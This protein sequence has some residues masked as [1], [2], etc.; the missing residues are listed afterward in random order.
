MFVRSFLIK[1]FGRERL[2]DFMRMFNSFLIT[3]SIPFS[4]N[5]F[6]STIYYMIF[7]NSL[8]NEAKISLLGRINYRS[9]KNY[10]LALLKR[11]IHRIEKGL[12][13]RPRKDDFAAEYIIQTVKLFSCQCKHCTF[14]MKKWTYDVLTEYFSV[15]IHQNINIITAYDIYLQITLE[16]NDVCSHLAMKP[17]KLSDRKNNPVDYEQLKMLCLYR[18]SVRSFLAI[19]VEIEK[20]EQ[21]I[22]IASLAPSACNRQ[23][24]KYFVMRKPEVA[25]EVAKLAMGTSGFVNEINCLIAVVGDLSCFDMPYDR[26]LIYIDSSLSTMQLLL[27]FETLGL[28]SCVLNWPDISKKDKIISSKLNLKNYEKVVFLIAVGYANPEAL[29]PFSCKKNVLELL[30]EI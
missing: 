19:Q 2:H 28:S 26:H 10:N 11:N 8:A 25:R 14:D 12:V 3:I 27:A 16:D 21:A 7:G 5:S 30:V 1:V 20:L 18:K 13:M 6:L 4:Y 24:F 9:K 15:V 23:P 22:K 29:T 17:Y